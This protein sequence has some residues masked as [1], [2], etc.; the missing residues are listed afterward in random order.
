MGD[1]FD[2]EELFREGYDYGVRPE[3]NEESTDKEVSNDVPPMQLLEGDQEEVK[4]GKGLTVLTPNKL[5]TWLSTLLAQIK[6]GN[7]SNKLK[8]QIRQILYLLHQHNKI[9]RKVYNNLIKWLK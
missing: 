7:N 6:A 3:N 4:E 1:K 5:L 9:T 2:P 8:K